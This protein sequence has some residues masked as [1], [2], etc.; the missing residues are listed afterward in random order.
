MSLIKEEQDVSSKPISEEGIVDIDLSE[1]RKKKFRL[2]GDNNRIIE[3]NTS[4]AGILSRLEKLYPKLQKLAQNASKSVAIEGEEEND[5]TS[6]ILSNID[7]Q[8]RKYIDEIFDSP[9][10]EKGA[11][12]G[13][14]CD[15]FN[16]KFRFEILLEKLLKLYGDNFTNE[17]NKMTKRMKKHTKKYTK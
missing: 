8:M 4:D 10:S 11:P 6:K 9:V 15:P 16:G 13:T 5:E 12:N 3:L 14:M 7:T 2:D 17:F 1:T